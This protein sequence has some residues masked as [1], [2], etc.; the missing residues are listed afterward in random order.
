MALTPYVLDASGADPQGEGARLRGLGPVALVELPGQVRAWAV[1]DAGLLRSLLGD[2]RVSKNPREHW[3]AWRTGRIPADW[4][5]RDW[6]SIR[7]MFTTDGEE[8]RRLRSAVTSSFSAARMA[9]FEPK[10]T[11]LVGELLDDLALRGKNGVVDLRADYA[12]RVPVRVISELFGFSGPQH[13]EFREI[14]SDLTDPRRDRRSQAWIEKLCMMLGEL[15]AD[16]QAAGRD[17]LTSEVVR[18][19]SARHE[20][21]SDSETVQMLVLLVVAG[22]ETTAN[23]LDQTMYALLSH[24][25]QLDLAASGT[26]SWADV[27]EE[28]LRWQAPV[29]YLPMR[30]ATADIQVGDITIA[31]GDAILAAYAAANRDRRVYGD[32]ADEF[33]ITRSNKQH[34]SFGHGVHFCIG[35][36]VARMA[37]KAAISALFGRF[38]R[39]SLAIAEDKLRPWP[40]LTGNGH[41][42]LPVLLGGAIAH[43]NPAPAISRD[44]STLDA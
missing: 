16:R 44:G 43:P 32:T 23:L 41:A 6:M 34:N 9:R 37:G 1:T 3:T 29:A 26:S 15:A 22:H 10:V 8:H 20:P 17:D 19:T 42:E 13:E 39:I 4:P 33:D 30:Y 36:P 2:P 40:S 21:L 24:P 11:G 14:V 31:Q 38:P 7:N 35:A 12:A 28:S 25:A 27:I 5:L 18:A